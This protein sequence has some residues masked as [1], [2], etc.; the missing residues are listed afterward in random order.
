MI[1]QQKKSAY[2]RA[3][4]ARNK[5]RV[6]QKMNSYNRAW[7]KA[8]PEKQTAMVRRQTAQRKASGTGAAGHLRRKH[9]LT[10]AAFEE[11]KRLAGNKCQVCDRPWEV[12]PD[13]HVV[14]HCHDTGKIK[15]ISRT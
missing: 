7:R 14:D 12:G 9:G 8:N 2:H 5:S 11:L 15:R 10:P 6:R 1:A 13:K 4:Y 3:W